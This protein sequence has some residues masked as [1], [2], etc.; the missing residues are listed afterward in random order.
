MPIKRRINDI[1]AEGSVF[2]NLH[3]NYTGQTVGILGIIGVFRGG[4]DDCRYE[5]AH[6]GIDPVTVMIEFH[7]AFSL[8]DRNKMKFPLRS[9]PDADF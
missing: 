4:I 9:A 3:Q 5:I 1:G 6:G 2:Q 7:A 8:Q